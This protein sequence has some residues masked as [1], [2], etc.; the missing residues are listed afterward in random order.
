MEIEMDKK[1]IRNFAI[2]ARNILIARV[3]AKLAKLGVTESGI[4]E[5]IQIDSSL[6]EI[7]GNRER[8]SGKDI[9]KRA[10]LIE[11]LQKREANSD[12]KISLIKFSMAP[13]F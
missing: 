4:D 13:R 7:K 9:V 2:N 6:I 5:I 3:G 1:A 8:F 11:E 12:S 10:K